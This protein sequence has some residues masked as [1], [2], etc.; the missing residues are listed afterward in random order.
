MNLSHHDNTCISQIFSILFLVIWK[1]ARSHL[2]VYPHCFEVFNGIQSSLF[3]TE[4]ECQTDDIN[5]LNP[6]FVQ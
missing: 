1:Y 5:L 3:D 6:V 4:I 2:A